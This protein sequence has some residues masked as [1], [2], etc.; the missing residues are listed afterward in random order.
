MTATFDAALSTTRDRLRFRLADTDIANALIADETY[1]GLLTYYAS[2]S[3][4]DL[5][6]L[7]ALAQSL[8]ARFGQQ[9]TQAQLGDGVGFTWGERVTIWREIVSEV[10]GALGIGGAAAIIGRIRSIHDPY[11]DWDDAIRAV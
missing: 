4:P 2:E 10:E 1:D 3:D 6:A 9:V 11:A 8:I 5:Y 7:R